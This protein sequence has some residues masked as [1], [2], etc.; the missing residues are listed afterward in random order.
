MN[1]S[2]DFGGNSYGG[3]NNNNEFNYSQGIFDFFKQHFYLSFIS[4]FLRF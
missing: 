4:A 2:S 1:Y 3:N